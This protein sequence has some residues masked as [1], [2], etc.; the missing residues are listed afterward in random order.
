MQFDSGTAQLV[1]NLISWDL[2]F[3]HL[4]FCPDF[5]L[6]FIWLF[7]GRKVIFLLKPFISGKNPKGNHF[8]GRAFKQTRA[9][10]DLPWHLIITDHKQSWGT[11]HKLRQLSRTIP[12]FYSCVIFWLPPK[13]WCHILCTAKWYLTMKVYFVWR[14]TNKWKA[15]V[16]LMNGLLELFNSL[17]F[18]HEVYM[19]V[20]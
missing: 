1:L 20:S 6:R 2:F 11:A 9:G 15:R 19:R 3:F 12:S 4:L 16:V 5:P 18:H 13:G 7:F 10:S 17:N 8:L 14:T